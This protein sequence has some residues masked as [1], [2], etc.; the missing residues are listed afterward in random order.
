MLQFFSRSCIASATKPD[1]TA[2]ADYTLQI[3]CTKPLDDISVSPLSFLYDNNYKFNV[4]N[5]NVEIPSNITTV[6]IQPKK[7]STCGKLTINGVEQDSAVISPPMEYSSYKVEATDNVF[8]VKTV[9]TVSVHR[10]GLVGGID[11]TA[12]TLSPAYSVSIDKYKLFL[13]SNVGSVTISPYPIG[14]CE[15]IL[16]QTVSVPVGGHKTVKFHAQDVNGP[17]YYITIDVYRIQPV[18]GISITGGSLSPAFSAGTKS[19][20][21]SVPATTS[22]VTV[23]PVIAGSC[24]SFT[25]NNQAV[26]SVV[27][28]PQVGGSATAVISAK[29][30]N[31]SVF[32][33]K[34]T[35]K[36][37]SLITSITA[38]AGNLSPLFTPTTLSYMVINVPSSTTTV[39]ITP[40]K[41]LTG[42]KSVTINGKAV[43]YAYIS[44][45]VG[46][47]LTIVITAS[48]NITKLTYTV[49]ITHSSLLSGIKFSNGSL[50]PT[51]S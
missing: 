10:V 28:Y 3:V 38:S 39:K 29:A 17:N 11:V 2:E 43:S 40:V 47:S 37:A 20:T 14:N 13:P 51:F 27:L 21:V 22:A 31:G 19:Y 9:Y 49:V 34:V 42:V 41:A 32:S 18:T 8:G 44:P 35:V 45:S 33:Y 36:R 23:K 25:I 12:G 46:G 24:S 1:G 4:K 26:P 7:N 15:N 48:D 6:K 50:A 5:E 30:V 16:P